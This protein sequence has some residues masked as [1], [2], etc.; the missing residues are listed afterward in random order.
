[1]LAPD[2]PSSIRNEYGLSQLIEVDIWSSDVT[3]DD[4]VARPA[5]LIHQRLNKLGGPKLLLTHA[6]L[7]IELKHFCTLVQHKNVTLN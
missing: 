3:V 4:R 6:A 2:P 7:R 5:S 1:M